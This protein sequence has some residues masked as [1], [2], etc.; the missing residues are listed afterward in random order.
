MFHFV[1]FCFQRRRL[2]HIAGFIKSCAP[3]DSMKQV[4]ERVEQIEEPEL[5]DLYGER[6]LVEEQVYGNM[7]KKS[8][9]GES[10][11]SKKRKKKSVTKKKRVAKKKV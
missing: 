5:M 8:T 9:T 11:G 6:A 1:F 2:R 4:L 7:A 10:S 3:D